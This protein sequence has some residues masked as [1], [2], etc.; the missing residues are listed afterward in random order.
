MGFATWAGGMPIYE[1]RTYI[2]EGFQGTLG[3]GFPT[4]LGVKAAN[5]DRAVV[6][7][8]GDGGFMFGMQELATAAQYDIGLVTLVFN[9]NAFGNVRRDQQMGFGGRLIG[10]DLKNPDFM[11]L[12]ESFGVAGYRVSTPAELKP[13][14]AKAI[15]DNKPALIEISTETGSEAAA[16]EFINMY[17]TPKL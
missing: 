6:S 11:K 5:P 17:E 9:N 12:A 2:S 15:D 13:V 1:P 10:A 3:F 8:N 7:V 16:W 4:A 14:L